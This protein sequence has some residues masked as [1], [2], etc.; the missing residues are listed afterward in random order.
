MEA[1]FK[2]N[3]LFLDIETVID[4]DLLQKAGS[5]KNKSQYNNN[6]FVS[7][8]VFHIPIC[9]S[10]LGNVGTEDFYFKTFISRE[11]PL[12]VDKF[13]SGFYLSIKQSKSKKSQY[14]VI[15]THNGQSFDMPILT[16]RAIKYYDTLSENA[17]NGLKEYLDTSD[18]WENDR[19]DYTSRNTL[20]HI[21]TYLLTNSY[22]S[23]KAL[24]M[25]NEIDS[26]TQMDG[27]QV[28]K[29]FKDNKLEEIAL[30]CAEDVL[31]LAKLFNKINIA[32]GN[33]SLVLPE[34]FNQCEVNV[35]A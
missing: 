18:K 7:Q 26:K 21:D 17:K 5:E 20:Y 10:V 29:Y 16:L 13:F 28:A 11:A 1:F 9:F 19:P 35:L 25:L 30:Y 34:N 2:M 15:V 12:T 31:S 32:R 14:P 6:E 22:S 33:N 3:Y 24:C 8:N 4:D 23:L 27:K